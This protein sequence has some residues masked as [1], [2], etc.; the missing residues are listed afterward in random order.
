LGAFAGDALLAPRTLLSLAL[1]GAL[2]CASPARAPEAALALAPVPLAEREMQTRVFA[3]DDGAAVLAACIAVLQRH[4]FVPED[5]DHALGVI[6]AVK[7][8]E[9]AGSRTRLRASLV[10]QPAGEFSLATGL[11]VT[12]QRLAWDERGREIQREAVRAPAEYAG[13]FE[14]VSAALALSEPSAE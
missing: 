7:H 11:R 4:G 6:V 10:T 12:F 2:G 5:Q 13:F 14:E 1:A 3:T 8:G 9:E